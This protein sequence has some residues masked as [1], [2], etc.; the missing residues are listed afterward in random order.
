M[1]KELIEKLDIDIFDEAI[2]KIEVNLFD[3]PY[4][5]HG[6]SHAK[7]VILI[8]RKLADYE[9][10]S[11]PE[12]T[13]LAYAGLYHDIGRTNNG[14][15]A[16]HGFNSYKKIVEL[17]LIDDIDLNTEELEIIKFIV[18]YHCLDDEVGYKA[19]QGYNIRD[20]EKA[21]LLFDIFK[22]AD[23]LDRVRINNFDPG[24]LRLE[25]SHKLISTAY[26]LFN[27]RKSIDIVT[28][29]T[30]S[31]EIIKHMKYLKSDRNYNIDIYDKYITGICKEF[32]NSFEIY[33]THNVKKLY[34]GA[35]IEYAK[36]IIKD[37]YLIPCR[38]KES[39]KYNKVYFSDNELY[40]RNHFISPVE[41]PWGT[42]DLKKQYIVFEIDTKEHDIYSYVDNIEWFILGNI[43]IKNTN[44]YIV[45]EDDSLTKISIEE[46]MKVPTSSNDP[47]AIVEP[48]DI[49]NL[50]RTAWIR[51]RRS[52]I[53]KL[54]NDSIELYF[55]KPYT[56]EDI[57]YLGSNKYIINDIVEV[58]EQGKDKVVKRYVVVLSIIGSSINCECNITSI[59]I[60]DSNKPFNLEVYKAKVHEEELKDLLEIGINI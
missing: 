42:Y 40:L 53:E 39:V 20:V 46:I 29:E 4:G 56:A 32:S 5:I 14:I 30:I 22:D 6:I 3:D 59:N 36:K 11:I 12:K 33:R 21:K 37:G 25:N 34:H 45:E 26:D 47:F 41:L 19:I 8:L 51:A 55:T 48:I 16:E 1:E 17:A 7:R 58:C 23:G 38:D 60:E 2:N 15:E 18:Q 28:L 35:P 24:F 43:N 31:P 27:K 52:V 54:R 13:L 57:D 10:L 9:S 49:E 50:K 44:I